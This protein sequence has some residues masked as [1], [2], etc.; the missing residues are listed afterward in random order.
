MNAPAK[1]SW[2]LLLVHIRPQKW[3]LVLGG[4]LGFIGGMAGLA[5]PLL[6][7]SVIDTFQVGGSMVG[8]IVTLTILVI[9][10]AALGALGA[11]VLERT[12]ETIVLNARLRLVSRMLRLRVPD[13]DRLKP[14]DLL[15]RVTADSTLLRAVCTS[16]VT[17]AITASLMLI[18][19][20]AFMAY[21]DAVL[22][23][24]TLGVLV[25][26][27]VLTMVVM[28][29]INRTT[30]QAQTA[31]GDMAATLDRALQAFR[32]VKAAG[33]EQRETEAVRGAAHTAWRKGVSA[34]GWRSLTGASTMLAVQ[35]SFLAVLG[36]G[37]M[38]VASGT[39][40]VSSLIAF[41]L[42]LFYLTGPISQLV[43]GVTQ[44]Q[45]G[46]A[47]VTRLREIEDLPAEP[48]APVEDTAPRPTAPATVTL[49]NVHFQYD[50]ERSPALNGITFTVPAG[51]MTA[52]VGPSGAGKST[53]FALL[54]RFYEPSSGT[55]TLDGRPLPDLP[56]P[57]LRRSLGYV[58]QDAPVLA[59]SLRDNLVFGNPDATDDD[60]A[61]VL[62]R[63]Q[64]TELVQ[65]LPEGLDTA[66]GHRG[67]MLS[68]GERQRVAI[69]RALLRKPR[70]LLL[71][72][73]TSQLDAVNELRLRDVIE[74]VA[75]TTTVLVIAHRLS[76]VTTADRIV[77]LEAG[78][79][80]A[81]GSHSELLDRDDLYRELATT[82]FLTGTEAMR[83]MAAHTDPA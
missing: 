24:V 46:L 22:L 21:M 80:R 73:A 56:L 45:T 34:A 57:D 41:L 67:Q 32:T 8:P 51:G 78:E 30:A 20:I 66:V 23:G 38:R 33:A 79:V 35:L 3:K 69:A 1:G 5:E 16:G 65:R 2:R 11:Y 19:C 50:T 54:E 81:I 36:V 83:P 68:G 43:N 48:V 12:A 25:V 72:E 13:V 63:T 4:L 75:G 10:G 52:L 7:K 17:D 76:T 28:P 71:D 6:A 9:V 60:I 15:S 18:G 55:I 44:L 39:L 53:M 26:I 77:V 82:Q 59:G 49:D 61:D 58:E 29:R 70:L 64:L 42:Y 47:A 31:L 27:G 37:G 74:E 40:P 62:R 14:G